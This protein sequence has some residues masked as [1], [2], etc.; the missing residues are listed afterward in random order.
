MSKGG[1][2]NNFYLS[3]HNCNNVVTVYNKSC[4]GVLTCHFG[5]IAKSIHH[6]RR[7]C[8]CVPQF[9]SFFKI[10]SIF[11][12]AID[13]NELTAINNRE[14]KLLCRIFTP[15]IGKWGSKL[16]S[17]RVTSKITVLNHCSHVVCKI[18]LCKTQ[19]ITW[20]SGSCN[21]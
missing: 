6:N 9:T 2:S 21:I 18:G 5:K 7:H 17:V 20:Y 10:E 15:Q 12:Y 1:F 3:P 14:I 16:H 4:W 13:V 11:I 8:A 19:H